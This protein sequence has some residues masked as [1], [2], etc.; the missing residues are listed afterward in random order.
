VFHRPLL[1]LGIVLTSFA[2]ATA[3]DI[4]TIKLKG[5][6][7]GQRIIVEKTETRGHQLTVVFTEEERIE[8]DTDKN[9]VAT[10]Y[11][12]VILECAPGPAGLL[13]LERKYAKAMTRDS[14]GKI[15]FAS[16]HG[17]SVLL[18][19]DKNRDWECSIMG[20]KES[21]GGDDATLL[22]DLPSKEDNNELSDLMIPSKSVRVGGE[23][24]IDTRRVAAILKMPHDPAPSKGSGR[25]AR[26]YRKDGRLY[27]VLVI[28][29][30]LAMKGA[31]GDDDPRPNLK[32]GSRLVLDAVQ[33]CCIDGTRIDTQRELS[34]TIEMDVRT[35]VEDKNVKG[36]GKLTMR[37]RASFVEILP[38]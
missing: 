9:V 17:K 32:A 30:E 12:Q 5:R 26:V 10:R 19:R 24:K 35:K 22:G 31:F 36:A 33:D 25:L 4:Y 29:M 2:P 1:I 37:T 28:H 8:K 23:W 16:F 13:R 11:E 27:G 3:D 38:D 34:V 7:K 14:E 21:L 6:A 18:K 20:A 15:R